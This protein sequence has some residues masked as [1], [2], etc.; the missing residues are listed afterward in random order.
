MDLDLD[1]YEHSTLVQYAD[2][3]TE[4]LTE[5][6]WERADLPDDAE[7]TALTYTFD[8]PEEGITPEWRARVGAAL[9][10]AIPRAESWDTLDESDDRDVSE[11]VV[12]LKA[13]V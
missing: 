5:A 3:E 13:G 2:G 10:A 4:W 12:D 6:E 8:A 11:F 9:L 7:V 1:T